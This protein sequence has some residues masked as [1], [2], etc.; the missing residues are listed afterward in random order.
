M[1]RQSLVQLFGD[2]VIPLAGVFLFEWSLYFILLFYCLDMIA[3]EIIAHLKSKK[4]I[5]FNGK[6]KKAWVIS[7]LKS[8]LL[9]IISLVTIHVA[10][11]FIHADIDFKKEFVAFMMYE[12]LGIP[13]GYVLVPLIAFSSY[14]V[15]RMNFLMPAKF[16][17]IQLEEV[18]RPHIQSLIVIILAAGASIGL[19]QLIIFPDWAYVII[20]VLVAFSYQ[21]WLLYSISHKR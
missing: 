6:D 8:V 7:G 13:Q 18:W 1:N 5:E 21:F 14:Q 10:V 11:Y 9:M 4:I 16:R 17:S 19:S 3:N 12:E 15:Y 2:A 20:I